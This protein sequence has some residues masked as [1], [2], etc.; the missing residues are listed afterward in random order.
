MEGV[1]N[2]A[3]ILNYLMRKSHV[4]SHARIHGDVSVI[5]YLM[6]I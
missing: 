6:L 3:K 4:I 1:M 5:I 2:F